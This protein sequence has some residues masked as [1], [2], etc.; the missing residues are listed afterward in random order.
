[1]I[2]YFVEMSTLSPTQSGYISFNAWFQ[3]SYQ[4]GMLPTLR[5]RANYIPTVVQTRANRDMAVTCTVW[6][7]G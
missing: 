7:E 1:M 2:R 6:S 4:I 5:P 3:A